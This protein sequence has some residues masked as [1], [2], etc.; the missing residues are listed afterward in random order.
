M[1]TER[2][3]TVFAVAEVAK[4]LK[5]DEKT[6]YRALHDGHLK[7]TRLGRTWRIRSAEVQAYLKRHTAR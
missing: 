1:D 4:A 7:G 2:V 6:V 5:L 3:E